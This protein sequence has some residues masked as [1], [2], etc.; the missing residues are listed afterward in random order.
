MNPGIII[1]VCLHH[2]HAAAG[3]SQRPGGGKRNATGANG[4]ALVP[5]GTR[6]T[7]RGSSNNRPRQP[8]EGGP[9]DDLERVRAI[10]W[11]LQSSPCTQPALKVARA[12]CD[13]LVIA[14]VKQQV[15]IRKGE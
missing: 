12:S 5:L 6:R 3:Q 9:G 13:G 4:N 10:S 14:S 2:L 8:E 7:R 1:A 15:A 11:R